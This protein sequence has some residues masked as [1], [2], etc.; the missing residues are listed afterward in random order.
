MSSAAASIPDVAFVNNS[1]QRTPCVLILDG[2]G[3]M[4]GAAID[5]VNAGLQ[6][7]AAELASDTVARERVRLKVLRIGDDDRIHVMQDWTDAI[8][9]Q[10]P[11]IDANGST[12]LGGALN[13]ALDSIESEKQ[14]MKSN[15][16]TYTRPLVWMITDGAATDGDVW[17]AAAARCSAAIAGKQ[18]AVFAVGTEGASFDQLRQM[19]GAVVMQLKGANFKELFAFLSRSVSTAS[20]AAPGA[21]TQVTLP[22]SITLPT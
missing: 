6:S 9:F 17:S 5:E 1:S 4:A 21:A 15:G 7:L 16:V 22:P 18:V 11:N 3:S 10:A 12:P 20:K 8:D 13:L 19:Q 2:S 14:L